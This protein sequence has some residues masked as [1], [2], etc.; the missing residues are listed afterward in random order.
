M[1]TRSEHSTSH[2]LTIIF[3]TS[4]AR[5]LIRIQTST[6]NMVLLLLKT[7]VSDDIRADIMTANMSP[8]APDGISF[9]TRYG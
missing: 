6:V 1:K 4:P 9:I 8:R 7:D 3:S 5:G 2:L